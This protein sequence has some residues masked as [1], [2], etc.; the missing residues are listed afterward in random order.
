M[1]GLREALTSLHSPAPVAI[2]KKAS[3]VP[4]NTGKRNHPGYEPVKVYLRKETHKAARRRSEDMGFA[5][6]SE[7]VE[8]LL[9]EWMERNTGA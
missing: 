6:F 2:A 8:Q 3:D 5:D 1:K 7:L 9:G 4:A